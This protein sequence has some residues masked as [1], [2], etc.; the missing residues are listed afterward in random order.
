MFRLVGSFASGSVLSLNGIVLEV[1]LRSS[2]FIT[3]L[4]F[5]SFEL[6]SIG[7]ATLFL[8]HA[9]RQEASTCDMKIVT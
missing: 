8:Q 9:L 1:N 3:E 6:R 2:N 7:I 4:I 5:Y